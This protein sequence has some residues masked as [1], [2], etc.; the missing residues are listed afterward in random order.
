MCL[1]VWSLQDAS[2][3]ATADSEALHCPHSCFAPPPALPPPAAS[4]PVAPV[5]PAG[6]QKPCTAPLLLLLL[7]DHAPKPATCYLL[8]NKTELFWEIQKLQHPEMTGLGLG[9]H[10]QPVLYVE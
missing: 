5:E 2:L 4:A 7:N 3:G 1:V 8:P 9:F 10:V 6:L